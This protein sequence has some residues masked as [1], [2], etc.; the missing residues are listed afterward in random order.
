MHPLGRSTCLCLRKQ[1]WYRS[2]KF[3]CVLYDGHL[4]RSV[5]IEINK[6]GTRVHQKLVNDVARCNH[7]CSHPC[8]F[9]NFRICGNRFRT[10]KMAEMNTRNRQLL[11]EY[12]NLPQ[13]DNLIQAMY[14]W[15]DGSGEGIRCK[16]RTIEVSA[17]IK[18]CEGEMRLSYVSY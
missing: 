16:T 2:V 7:T 14:M 1:H 8:A 13:P 18:C 17:D 4:I 9:H 6:L 12:M 11:T 15:I 3:H 5:L 10:T